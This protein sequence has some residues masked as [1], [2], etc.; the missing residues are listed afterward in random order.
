MARSRFS[1]AARAVALAGFIAFTGGGG[2]SSTTSTVQRG[3]ALHANARWALLPVANHSETPQAGE[4]VEAVLETL[5]RRAGVQTLEM[6]PPP[7]QDESHLL[8]DD[9]HRYEEALLWAKGQQFHYAV[10]GSVEEWRYKNG[11][12]GEPA[13]GLTVKISE[14]PT[15]R[16]LWSAS[17]T[18][19]G[20]GSDNASGTALLLLQTLTREL[21]MLA[22]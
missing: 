16:V 8:V 14:V 4:R 9:R 13:V 18:R 3:P 20:S 19:T 5:L 12:E 7:K 11:V 22:R 1:N 15:G 10:S 17:G 6:Y 21:D 2:C